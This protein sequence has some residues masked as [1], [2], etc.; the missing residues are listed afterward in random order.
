MTLSLKIIL[1]E[2]LLA[3]S[4]II[5]S[6][7]LCISISKARSLYKKEQLYDLEKQRTT[8]NKVEISTLRDTVQEK[9]NIIV[10]LSKVIFAKDSI[11]TDTNQK[12]T[13][14]QDQLD[15]S[16]KKIIKIFVFLG[17]LSTILLTH[18]LGKFSVPNLILS[19]FKKTI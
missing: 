13:I 8:I 11:I 17:I 10:F 1:S 4:K 16:E 6:D 18:F 9:K 7:T 5:E 12:L 2:Y 19:I 15:V 14:S 3:Q